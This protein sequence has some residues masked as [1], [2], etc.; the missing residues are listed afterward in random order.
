MRDLLVGLV[1]AAL[2]IAAA[3]QGLFVASPDDCIAAARRHQQAAENKDAVARKL[4]D[5][6]GRTG[7][8]VE[9]A[10]ALTRSGL[11][12]ISAS[13]EAQIEVATQEERFLDAQ[14]VLRDAIMAQ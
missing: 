2:P 9:S 5:C 4:A 3:A 6:I 7:D 1:A 8:P 12:S 14:R 13:A 10:R 11:I